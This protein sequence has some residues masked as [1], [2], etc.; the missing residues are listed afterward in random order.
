MSEFISFDVIHSSKIVLKVGY[1]YLLYANGVFRSII[2][3]NRYALLDYF[4]CA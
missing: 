2:T 1:M 3:G 4:V